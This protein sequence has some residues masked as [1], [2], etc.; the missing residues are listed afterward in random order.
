M[1]SAPDLLALGLSARCD[2]G[3]E[4]ALDE[5]AD[6]RPAPRERV[7]KAGGGPSMTSSA[8]GGTIAL[9]GVGGPFVAGASPRSSASV[10]ASPRWSLAAVSRETAS[11]RTPVCSQSGGAM[12]MMR[13]HLE[14]GRA[15]ADALVAQELGRVLSADCERADRQQEK[16]Q[17]ESA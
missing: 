11:L 5:A 13:A 2:D 10:T 1:V 9:L 7:E 15:A 4:P 6:L 14:A 12:R 8:D 3:A 17:P 16:R